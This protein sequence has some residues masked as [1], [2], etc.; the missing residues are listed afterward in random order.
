M[1]MVC[2]LTNEL[3]ATQVLCRTDGKR[4]K[5]SGFKALGDSL[6]CCGIDHALPIY[7]RKIA[8]P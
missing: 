5:E 1:V 8:H 7:I 6:H 2:S 3:Y 4:L